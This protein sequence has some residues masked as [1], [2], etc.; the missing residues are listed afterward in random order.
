ML[1]FINHDADKCY[2]IFPTLLTPSMCIDLHLLFN[3]DLSSLGQRMSL[4]FCS[5]VSS[6]ADTL[7]QGEAFRHR[8][9][10]IM[11]KLNTPLEAVVETR[12]KK[13][14]NVTFRIRHVTTILLL[15]SKLWYPPA[16]TNATW[17]LCSAETVFVETTRHSTSFS[18]SK[19]SNVL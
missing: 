1:K 14:Q 17:R 18:T 10:M 9:M 11:N 4:F 12:G 5:Y 6:F 3:L 8:E 16:Q 2:L 19:P 7:L 13:T 15:L